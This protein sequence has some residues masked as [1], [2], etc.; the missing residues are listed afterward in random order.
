MNR[1]QRSV[2]DRLIRLYS[3]RSQAST[4]HTPFEDFTTEI[5]ASILEQNTDVLKA[6]LTE[7]FG[8]EREVVDTS[9]FKVKTQDHYH[10]DGGTSC[11]V[12]LTIRGEDFLCFVENKV[13]STE[14]YRQLDRYAALL[15]EQKERNKYLGYCT[16]YSEESRKGVKQY[17]WA[18][19]HRLLSRFHSDTLIANFTDFLRRNGMESS[20]ELS[21]HDLHVMQGVV[22]V[23]DKLGSILAEVKQDYDQISGR[24]AKCSERYKQIGRYQRYVC[25]DKKVLSGEGYSELGFGFDLSETPS[26]YVWIWADE[27]SEIWTRHK[28]RLFET[29]PD[30][31]RDDRSYIAYLTP[32]SEFLSKRDMQSDIR[33][34]FIDIFERIAQYEG[35]KRNVLEP[36][37]DEDTEKEM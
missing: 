32:L 14:G 1:A 4:A 31:K 20:N 2:F 8:I 3:A 24:R 25:F 36:Q 17:R 29:F 16:K 34:W 19:V 13:H 7:I 6:F 15:A 33:R 23:F 10:V 27:K 28:D 9:R 22:D 21:L 18:D 11:R 30:G 12:D 37:E 5:F 26:L 35:F